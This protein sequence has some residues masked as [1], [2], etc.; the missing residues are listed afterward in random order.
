MNWAQSTWF[1]VKL[2]HKKK[3]KCSSSASRQARHRGVI[4]NYKWL[5]FFGGQL[6][7]NYGSSSSHGTER[8][9]RQTKEYRNAAEEALIVTELV[10]VYA[11]L[12]LSVHHFWTTGCVRVCCFRVILFFW[13]PARLNGFVT[14]LT[15][16]S[17][18]PTDSAK[19][20]H[21][22]VL[23]IRSETNER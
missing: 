14:C 23:P 7:L 17:L 21:L 16:T 13:P 11:W 1:S 22:Q 4:A 9:P 20:P 8:I 15:E 3:T 6:N 19:F 10:R 12:C 5:M 18:Q 2:G